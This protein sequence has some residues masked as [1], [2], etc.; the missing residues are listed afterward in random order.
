M[1][2][3]KPPGQKMNPSNKTVRQSRMLLVAGMHV[4]ILLLT[5]VLLTPVYGLLYLALLSLFSGVRFAIKNR[6]RRRPP[7]LKFTR[8]GKYVVG[9]T[10]G[11]GLAAINTGNNLLYLFLGMLLS[12]IIISGVLS[13]I[14]LSKLKIS[15]RFPE[16]IFAKQAVLVSVVLRNAKKHIPS[17]SVQVDDQLDRD[18]RAKRCFFL[19]LKPN[20]Q[21]ST[22]YRAEFARRGLY[23]FSDLSLVTR[24][25]FSFFI[26]QKAIRE[27][28]PTTVLVY[29][30]LR[31]IDIPTAM[32]SQL[33]G[34]L[35]SP[36]RGHGQDFFGLNEY[37]EGQNAK[38]I[39]WT[40][41]A[42]TDRLVLKEFTEEKN[43]R[44]RIFLN[45]TFFEMDTQTNPSN[46]TAQSMEACVEIAASL[47]VSSAQAQMDMTL[48]TP[49]QK[50]TV[51]AD[52]S[53]LEACLRGLALIQ[54]KTVPANHKIQMSGQED[55]AYLISE[56]GAL[57]MLPTLN[58]TIVITP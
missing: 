21:Q 1:S 26:K 8:E 7:R 23:T 22:S 55:F 37:Q 51:H 58:D 43:T 12:L 28:A 11:V 3:L 52:G 20:S 9:I 4:C 35:T 47:V 13:E 38:N 15:R 39:H 31:S 27:T 19:K 42:S 14:T 29:P 41:S 44:R 30:A 40:R 50:W 46:D 54:F 56:R 48:V 17:F 33:A 24:F 16:H 49:H 32:P 2:E 53:G 36:L 6:G 34:Q 57:A 25:P 45:D 5:S 10:I 18:G